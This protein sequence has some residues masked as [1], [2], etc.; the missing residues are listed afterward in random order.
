MI[1][2]FHKVTVL[3]SNATGIREPTMI[4]KQS[5][6]WI[7]S[8]RKVVLI[9]GLKYPVQRDLGPANPEDLF[10]GS[11]PV[12]GYLT[13]DG[14]QI[15]G[16]TLATPALLLVRDETALAEKCFATVG[17][18]TLNPDI[19]LY[20]ELSDR[21]TMQVAHF[22]MVHNDPEALEWAK[23]LA[24][25]SECREK[26]GLTY[27]NDMT[28]WQLDTVFPNQLLRDVTRRT[29]HSKSKFD[30]AAN[31]KIAAK[32]VI[33]RWLSR[34]SVNWVK[35]ARSNPYSNMDFD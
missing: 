8:D 16:P 11:A 32:K 19:N 2:E 3:V 29:E 26:A 5:Y 28:G 14:I 17:L 24:D 13:E 9:D 35:V 33:A 30:L 12:Y 22:L 34:K 4:E 18:R 21:Y 27:G 6:G 7:V 25:V 23:G 15:T 1:R 20:A 31:T 10:S